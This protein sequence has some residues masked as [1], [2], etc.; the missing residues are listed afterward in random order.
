MKFL[1]FDE[2]AIVCVPTFVTLAMC[3]GKNA[4]AG[5]CSIVFVLA[6]VVA[7]Y[8]HHLNEKLKTVSQNCTRC[9]VQRAKEMIHTIKQY[10]KDTKQI[11]P[12]NA[13]QKDQIL[14][15]LQEINTEELKYDNF[16]PN[17]D[18]VKYPNELADKYFNMFFKELCSAVLN[19]GKQSN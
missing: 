11:T 2:L 14:K 1:P 18:Y 15:R 9:K 12:W 13:E 19:N 7:L 17:Y 3:Y 6:C 4:P 10:I 16:D 8:V 5:L